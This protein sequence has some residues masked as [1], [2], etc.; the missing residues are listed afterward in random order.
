MALAL[1]GA[2]RPAAG[3][4]SGQLAAAAAASPA[5]YSQRQGRRGAAAT[6]H[7]DLISG[8]VGLFLLH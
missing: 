7:P 1:L 2:G 8:R 5:S 3:S 4:G 6:P